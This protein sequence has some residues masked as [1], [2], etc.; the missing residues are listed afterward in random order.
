MQRQELGFIA[1]PFYMFRVLSAPISS[2]VM[3]CGS[4]PLAQHVFRY[5]VGV[6]V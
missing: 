6:L 4:L 3:K 2:S 5:V 1:S